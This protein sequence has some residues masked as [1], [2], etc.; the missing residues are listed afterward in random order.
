MGSILF[1]GLKLVDSY[2]QSYVSI[3]LDETSNNLDTKPI[4]SVFDLRS[5]RIFGSTPNHINYLGFGRFV[6]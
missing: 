1:E 2:V 6:Y 3:D 5:L 4:L